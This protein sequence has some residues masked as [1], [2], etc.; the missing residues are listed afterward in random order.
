MCMLKEN[1]IFAQFRILNTIGHAI[2]LSNI[3]KICGSYTW[4]YSMMCVVCVPISMLKQLHLSMF[5][6]FS[7]LMCTV[8]SYTNYVQLVIKN[9]Y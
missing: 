5:Y 6:K 1:Y 9:L 8:V 7:R 3:L 4:H 2:W